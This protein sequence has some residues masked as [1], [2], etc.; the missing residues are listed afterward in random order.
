MEEKPQRR[1]ARKEGVPPCGAL[2]FMYYFLPSAVTYTNAVVD[3]D[4]VVDD[5]DDADAVVD[6]LCRNPQSP[7]S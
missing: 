6:A 5:G 4:A 1:A 3:V 2:E 7:Q